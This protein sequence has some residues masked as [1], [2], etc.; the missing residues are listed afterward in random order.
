MPIA[1]PTAED[2]GDLNEAESGRG[3]QVPALPGPRLGL[4]EAAEHAP[5][6]IGYGLVDS[7]AGQAAWILEK[8]WAWTDND[9]HP[10]DA[11]TRD[12]LLDN[13][14]MYWLNGAA[15]LLGPAST[16]RA[17]ATS[18]A[19]SCRSRPASRMFPREILGASRRWAERTY[20]D[21]RYWNEVDRGGHFAAF[22]EP[23]LFV[24]ELRACFRPLR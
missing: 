10:E 1:F 5:Q 17:S 14:M 22:E 4:L 6:T 23:D 15:R 12:E 3:R 19:S 24:D 11:L 8:F 20:T 7:P 16:G 21:L 9:G 18:A 13:V 2:M